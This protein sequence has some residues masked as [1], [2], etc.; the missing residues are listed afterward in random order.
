MN[1]ALFMSKQYLG[2]C[3]ICHRQ[4]SL[5]ISQPSNVLVNI[6]RQLSLSREGIYTPLELMTFDLHSEHVA[7]ALS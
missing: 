1:K 5:S 3:V 4:R 7:V 6:K 2:Q